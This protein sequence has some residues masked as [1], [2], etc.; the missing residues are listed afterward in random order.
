M[1]KFLIPAFLFVTCFATFV[2][3]QPQTHTANPIDARLYEVFDG[4]YLE[5]VNTENPFLIQRWNYYLDHAWYITDL[6]A[7]KAQ[8]GYP[9]IN[10]ENPEH[11]NI[12]L[13]EKEQHLKRDWEKQMIYRIGDSKKALVF[14]PGKEFNERLNEHLGR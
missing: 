14:Y 5:K 12:L 1:K 11:F 3:A 7:E 9:I 4:S 10:L 6:P 2:H 8:A 13:V